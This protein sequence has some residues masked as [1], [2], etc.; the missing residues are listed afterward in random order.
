MNRLIHWLELQQLNLV[1]LGI[2]PFLCTLIAY[3]LNGTNPNLA[4]ISTWTFYSIDLAIWLLSVV[5]NP[6]LNGLGLDPWIVAN[7]IASM[8]GGSMFA[9]G[10]YCYCFF[11]IVPGGNS[12]L[13]TGMDKIRSEMAAI[14]MELAPYKHKKEAKQILKKTNTGLFSFSLILAISYLL[15]GG[16]AVSAFVSGTI[17][18]FYLE[19]GL[20]LLFGGIFWVFGYVIAPFLIHVLRPGQRIELIHKNIDRVTARLRDI[21]ARE[22]YLKHLEKQEQRQIR[23]SKFYDDM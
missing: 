14:R 23:G 8:D 10:F 21:E 22:A 1:V 7:P 19:F 16:I 9:T 20:V 12:I 3:F 15:P 18:L 5:V 2:A 11:Q 13:L 4:E 17:S 6:V